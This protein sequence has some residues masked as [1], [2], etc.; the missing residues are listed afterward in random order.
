V[1]VVGEAAGEIAAGLPRIH[2]YSAI[3][4]AVHDGVLTLTLD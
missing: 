1:V 2:D 3:T 4:A